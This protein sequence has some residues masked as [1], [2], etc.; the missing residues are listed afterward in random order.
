MWLVWCIRCMKKK[1]LLTPDGCLQIWDLLLHFQFC[2]CQFSFDWFANL[3]YYNWSLHT[4]EKKNQIM[5]LNCERQRIVCSVCDT[6]LFSYKILMRCGE[7]M[8]ESHNGI[9]WKFSIKDLTIDLRGHRSKTCLF[10]IANC[11]IFQN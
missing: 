6:L 2:T 9:D 5:I 11:N 1:N 7:W 3:N 10:L 8:L 4:D